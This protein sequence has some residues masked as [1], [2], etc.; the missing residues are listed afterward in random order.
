MGLRVCV[1][2]NA[3]AL[4][5]GTIGTT[6]A[7]TTARALR[8]TRHSTGKRIFYEHWRYR[9]HYPNRRQVLLR[10][11]PSAL[12]HSADRVQNKASAQRSVPLCGSVVDT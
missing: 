6:P 3:I 4:C 9:E 12:H 11:D 1:L 7:V 8:A 2:Q 5:I 10:S